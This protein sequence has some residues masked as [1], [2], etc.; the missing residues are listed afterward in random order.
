[1]NALR[2]G[3]SVFASAARNGT[4]HSRNG[5]EMQEPSARSARRRSINQDWERKV[6][7]EILLGRAC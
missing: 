5:S 6:P 4:M 3:L 2:F 1:M 7:I